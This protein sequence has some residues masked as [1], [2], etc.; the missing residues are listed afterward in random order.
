MA[1]SLVT[2]IKEAFAIEYSGFSIREVFEL[3]SVAELAASIDIL[4][5]KQKLQENENLIDSYKEEELEE[6][7]L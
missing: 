1:I 4:L 3:S 7:V 6:G 2:Q 5:S